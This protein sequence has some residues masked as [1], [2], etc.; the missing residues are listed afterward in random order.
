MYS[1]VALF[2]V[3]DWLFPKSVIIGYI[4]VTINLNS[5]IQVYLDL[6]SRV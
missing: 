6:K 1:L 2:L 3:C 5:F 4:I